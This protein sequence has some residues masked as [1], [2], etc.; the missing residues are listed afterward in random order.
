MMDSQVRTFV[1]RRE[2]RQ[3]DFNRTWEE[4]RDGFGSLAADHWLGLDKL[5]LL[6]SSRAYELRFR[7]RLENGSVYYHFYKDFV[8]RDQS[9]GYSFILGITDDMDRELGDCLTPLMGASFSTYDNDSDGDNTT[10]CAQRHGAGWWFLGAN[11][12]S[13]NPLGPFINDT[14]LGVEAEA[15]WTDKMGDMVPF[16][17]YGYLVPL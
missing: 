16:T 13:C 9:A 1:V 15:F 11:C 7:V 17:L 6:T 10:N 12:S 8:V 3:L 2:E 4:Y 14:R 5:H